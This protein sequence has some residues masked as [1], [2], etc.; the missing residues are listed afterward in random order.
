MSQENGGHV[1]KNSS[2]LQ[3]VGW[4]SN[5]FLAVFPEMAVN[6]RM[7]SEMK[8]DRHEQAQRA[9]WGFSEE[10]QLVLVY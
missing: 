3:I 8:W 6:K 7:N 4:I 10:T 9:F 2:C 1:K 5:R